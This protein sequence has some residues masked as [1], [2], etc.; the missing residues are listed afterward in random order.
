[1]LVALAYLTGIV[2]LESQRPAMELTEDQFWTLI[3]W[4][5]FGALAGSK[6]LFLAVENKALIAGDLHPLR[7][8]RF[9]FVFFG[10]VIGAIV[11]G[12]VAARRLHKDFW[13]LA[14]YFGVALP[15]GHWIGRL[16]CLAAG[17][18]YGRPTH[19]PWGLRLGDSI[20]SLTPRILWGVPLHPTQ[21]YEGICDMA[22]AVF[23][24]RALLPRVY[25]KK[26]VPGT[27]FLSCLLL[28]SAARFVN[29]FFRGDDRGMVLGSLYISQW[30]ALAAIT[31]S[32][33]FMFRRGVRR[34]A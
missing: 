29:E 22:I 23:L 10:G 8:F 21:L 25:A 6:L 26:L 3:Y 33:L 12:M 17:C 11:V 24:W 27:V 9:G 16:G 15:M 2:W 7:D 1:M 19:M 4:V 14:D 5:F 13:A 28:Y 31:S 34:E 30:I 20:Y 18:C 32:V